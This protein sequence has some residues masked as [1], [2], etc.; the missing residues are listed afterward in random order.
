MVKAKQKQR[1]PQGLSLC[2][3]QAAAIEPYRAAK[4]NALGWLNGEPNHF[5]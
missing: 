4:A 3:H 2:C 5:K 1:C